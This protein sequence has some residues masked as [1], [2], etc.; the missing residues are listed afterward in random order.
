MQEI[1]QIVVAELPKQLWLAHF[2]RPL[3]GGNHII[4]Q[5][6]Q[7]VFQIEMGELYNLEGW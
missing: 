1:M 2:G 4:L 5:L 6:L 3:A 7:T